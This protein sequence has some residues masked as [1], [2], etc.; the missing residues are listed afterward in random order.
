MRK[1]S[2]DEGSHLG[3]Y[4]WNSWLKGNR[5]HLS[6]HLAVQGIDA[7]L[8][9]A[10]RTASL[11]AQHR[12]ALHVKPELEIMLLEVQVKSRLLVSA[13]SSVKLLAL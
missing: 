1:L 11:V 3:S 8:R 12:A 4:E 13:R 7:R 10:E 5:G 6:Y 2:F 9:L